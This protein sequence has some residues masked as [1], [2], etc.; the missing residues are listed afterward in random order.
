MGNAIM[1]MMQPYKN[2]VVT[3][4]VLAACLYFD[5]PFPSQTQTTEWLTAKLAYVYSTH[6]RIFGEI[7]NEHFDYVAVSY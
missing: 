5:Y 3:E 4:T 6:N 2:L 1:G 7:P